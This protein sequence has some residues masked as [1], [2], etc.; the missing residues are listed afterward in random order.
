M[1]PHPDISIIA[2][3]SIT[4]NS[5][6]LGRPNR[7]KS[8]NLCNCLRPQFFYAAYHVD[9]RGVRQAILTHVAEGTPEDAEDVSDN[10]RIFEPY[11]LS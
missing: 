9:V 7:S 6:W 8:I 3:G 5:L 11:W 1:R 10:L 2:I 4:Y